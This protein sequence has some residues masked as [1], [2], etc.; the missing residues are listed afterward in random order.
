MGAGVSRQPSLVPFQES[1][2]RDAHLQMGTS[3]VLMTDANACKVPREP[4]MK[5]AKQLGNPAVKQAAGEKG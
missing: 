5:K 1:Y 3:S 2:I 4:E